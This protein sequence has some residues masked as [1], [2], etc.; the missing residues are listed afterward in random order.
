[1]DRKKL[2]TDF[3][4]F[5]DVT[6]A[7]AQR[8][9][10][11]ET[12]TELLDC[13]ITDTQATTGYVVLAAGGDSF[14]VCAFRKHGGKVVPT[15]EHQVSET[16]I[17]YAQEHG[18][19]L[20]NTPF[21]Q[22][23]GKGATYSFELE[24]VKGFGTVNSA[25]VA[26]FAD[27]EYRFLGALGL[28]KAHDFFSLADRK[29]AEH[30]A[31]VATAALMTHSGVVAV[32]PHEIPEPVPGLVGRIY[33]SVA[34]E[35]RKVAKHGDCILITGP[36]G[37]GKEAFANAFHLW[38]GRKGPF[39]PVNAATLTNELA[40][41]ELFGYT[42]GAFTGA[43]S[44]H[45]GLFEQAKGGTIFLDEVGEMSLN[46]QT[47][48]LRALEVR[49]IRPVGATEEH[50]IDVRVVAATNRD[51]LQMTRDGTFREDVYDRLSAFTFELPRL[52][53]HMKDLPA[54]VH[55]LRARL[56]ERL[57][58]T[59][60]IEQEALDRLADYDWPGNVRELSNVVW[61]AAILADRQPI[62]ADHVR[63][64]RKRVDQG[65]VDTSLCVQDYKCMLA[66]SALA[67]GES[68][69][70]AAREAGVDRTT[71]YTWIKQGRI[72]VPESLAS[73]ESD[74]ESV[75]E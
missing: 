69:A 10:P 22:L 41:N 16:L 34:A 8:K 52:K 48:L 44:D 68:K 26:P 39:V 30:Y 20:T 21:Q 59:P 2:S 47:K 37:T 40:E 62:R 12:L 43:N 14:R 25:I 6:R 38:S 71:L 60:A 3:L 45:R 5:R 61:K 55:K 18:T 11:D 50:A 7:V 53:D 36:P 13:A 66:E 49:K 56:K 74:E 1:M 64:N 57:G 27:A 31:A 42:K 75:G 54:I 73:E 32:D 15:K 72:K 70:K 58:W 19:L 35:L 24:T 46:V 28:Y 9:A 17:E 51:L 33:E 63:I 29:T 67:R 23:V 4:R 65:E